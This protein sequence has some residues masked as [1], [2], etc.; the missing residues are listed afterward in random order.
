MAICEKPNFIFKDSCGNW[1]FLTS[2]VPYKP[3]YVREIP[4]G[5]CKGC[6][7]NKS[8]HYKKLLWLE[9]ANS[10]TAYFLTLTYNNNNLFDSSTH[11]KDLKIFVNS[12]YHYFYDNF[13][14]KKKFSYFGVSEYGDK[15]L[16]PHYHLIIFNIPILENDFY[17]FNINNLIKDFSYKFINKTINNDYFTNNEIK[18]IW[19]KGNIIISVLNDKRIDY[20]CDYLFKSFN[21]YSKFN[22]EKFKKRGFELPTKISS[23]N[24]GKEFILNNKNEFLDNGFIYYKGN[25]IYSDKYIDIKADLVSEERSEV[26]FIKQ[27]EKTSLNREKQLKKQKEI[28]NKK[29]IL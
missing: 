6:L 7:E 19:N 10:K 3:F 4:C 12:L 18:R 5:K 26:R 27:Y 15:T 22:K 16:R 17:K 29:G 2:K 9:Y 21:Y 25:K 28:S 24:L 14:I 8:F 20:C 23:H 1:K 13:G 11:I